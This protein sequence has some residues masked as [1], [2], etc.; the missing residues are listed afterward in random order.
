M[1][2]QELFL[3]YLKF[4][5]RCSDHTITAYKKDLSQFA[6]F[7][8]V[9]GSFFDV[10]KIK[11]K[12]VR[13]WVVFLSEK[14]DIPKTISRKVTSLKSFYKFLMRRG[15]VDKTPADAVIVPKLTKKLPYFLDEKSINSLLDNGYFKKDFEGIRDKLIISLF[16]DTGIRLSELKNLK[17]RDIR[18]KEFSIR[19][20]GKNN[21]ERIIPYPRSMEK[22]VCE[23][24]LIRN[25][26]KSGIFPF[27]FV[28]L[29][30]KPLYDKLIYRVVEKYLSMV[31]TLE[32]KSPHVLRHTF[33]THLLNRGADLNAV[34]ELLGHS[35]LVA[36]QIYTH[37]SMDKIQHVYKQAHPWGEEKL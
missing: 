32:K 5:K 35:N 29:K 4:E 28:T 27:F 36:T 18:E 13:D 30:G 14:G 19:V 21:K 9:N 24:L 26:K 15:V 10:K 1:S 3:K 20:L 31:T 7:I 22:L 25:K 12:D 11:R 16:Y 37:T 17:D 33:A 34:K 8:T 6:D 23:Y 2:C